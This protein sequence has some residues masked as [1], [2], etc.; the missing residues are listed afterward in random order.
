M[1]KQEEEEKS[2]D[3]RKDA[4]G[5]LN[6]S[7]LTQRIGA[8]SAVDLPAS[9]P[10]PARNSR[11]AFAR[12][13]EPELVQGFGPELTAGG[14][15]GAV[16]SSESEASSGSRSPIKSLFEDISVSQ[17]AAGA[18]A[19]VTSMLLSAQIGIT[20]SVIGVAVGSIVSA[21]SSQV[22]KKFL[23]ASAEKIQGVYAEHSPLAGGGMSGGDPTTAETAVLSGSRAA[24][25][26]ADAAP[27]VCMDAATAVL[28]ETRV[29]GGAARSDAASAAQLGV[30]RADAMPTAHLGAPG[31]LSAARRGDGGMPVGAAAPVGGKPADIDVLRARVELRRKKQMHRRVV[32]VSVASAVVAVLVSA[33]AVYLVTSGEGIGVKASVGEWATGKA[34]SAQVEQLPSSDG[35]SSASSAA[36]AAGL[37][38]DAGDDGASQNGQADGNAGKDEAGSNDAAAGEGGDAGS[39]DGSN[40]GSSTNGSGDADGDAGAGSSNGSD[41]SGDQGTSGGS[42]QNQSGSSTDGGQQSGSGSGQDAS[43]TA[44]GTSSSK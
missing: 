19:A 44:G 38:Q 33:G 36:D 6:D 37:S 14:G 31:E 15:A 34:P 24:S 7:A 23:S 10:E 32:A 11:S 41:G 29:E 4:E 20:G 21:V 12:G 39:T 3:L 9:E 27:T 8:P 17:L 18:L 25:V 22:Y 40:G 35:A 28:S 13:D 26:G 42:G 43:S 16:P 2:V 30:L 5:A 1:G